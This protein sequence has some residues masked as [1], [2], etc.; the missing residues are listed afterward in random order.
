MRD[1]YRAYHLSCD[2]ILTIVHHGRRQVNT[3]TGKQ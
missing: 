2:D 1:Q 3:A